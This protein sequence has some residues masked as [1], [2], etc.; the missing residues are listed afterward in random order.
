M[1]FSYVDENLAAIRA[2]IDAAAKRSGGREVTLVAAVKYT[3]TDH[4]N[5]LHSLGVNDI[6]ENRV[7][8]L[9]EH[10]DALNRENLRVHFIGTLQKN[11]VKYI[12]DKVSMIH[13]L[14]SLSLAQEIE[15]QAAKHG[16]VMDVLV[17]INSGMEENKSGI[18]PDEAA[19]FC[20]ALTQFSHLNLRGFM[21]MAPKCEKNEEYRQYFRKT[22]QLCL[23]IWQKNLHNIGR[24][25]LSM[26]MS[27]SFEVA[28]EEGADIVRV[29]R[30]LFASH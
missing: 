3:D 16:I 6:G 2:R 1:A 28:I 11:K 13:S 20:E 23:D 24:P 15:K 8:Q 9:L 12:I 4:I 18:S 26:G 14:D 27:D 17:E 29:G 19:A 21:T 7:Q 5:Y 25:I 10:W 30:A 22:S